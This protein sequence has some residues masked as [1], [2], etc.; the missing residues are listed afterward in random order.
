MAAKSFGPQPADGVAHAGDQ[1]NWYSDVSGNGN[2]MSSW[3]DGARPASTTNIPFATIQGIG[4]N[5]LALDF[6]AADIGPFGPE[7]G[8][9]MVESYAFTNGW[10]IEC[11]FKAND[12]GAWRVML[13]KD[14]KKGLGPEQPFSFKLAPEAEPFGIRCLVLDDAD[15]FHFIDTSEIVADKWYTVVATYDNAAFNV[16]LKS[17]DDADFTLEGSLART[18]PITFGGL[19]TNTWTIGRGMWTGVPVDH[20]YGQIDEIRITHGARLPS[21]FLQELGPVPP[22]GDIAIENLGTGNLALT[23]DTGLFH[24]YVL[25]EKTSLQDPTWSTNQAGIP[26]TETNVTVNVSTAAED[27]TFYAVSSEE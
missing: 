26:G 2:H 25:L 1:D 22:I 5:T 10:T 20:W 8:A 12:L 24:S 16:Y 27:E 14:G 19:N 23:W 3:A 7:T 15:A 17:E 18:Q 13:G 6:N 21:E 9:K 4:P 11:S